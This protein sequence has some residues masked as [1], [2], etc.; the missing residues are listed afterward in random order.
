MDVRVVSELEELAVG[1]SL[2]M[3][4]R[5]LAARLQVETPKAGLARGHP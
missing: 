5:A 4:S 2:R 3:A 1:S